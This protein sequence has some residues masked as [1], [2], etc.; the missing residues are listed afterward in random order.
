[1]KVKVMAGDV[2]LVVAIT[3]EGPAHPVLYTAERRAA[4]E[5]AVAVGRWPRFATDHVPIN[6]VCLSLVTFNLPKWSRPEGVLQIR[7][8]STQHSARLQ[9]RGLSPASC[10]HGQQNY[11]PSWLEHTTFSRPPV[12]IGRQH[13]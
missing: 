5:P 10:Q 9:R 11:S 13:V 3:H 6:G 2:G 7:A 8:D 12:Y 4:P 1:M